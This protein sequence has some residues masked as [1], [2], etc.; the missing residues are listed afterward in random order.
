MGDAGRRI[1]KVDQLTDSS[2]GTADLTVAAVSGS[3]ADAD[4]NNNFAE[5][6]TQLNDLIQKLVDCGLMEK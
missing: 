4:I 2:G 3:G 1:H 5:L 6:T